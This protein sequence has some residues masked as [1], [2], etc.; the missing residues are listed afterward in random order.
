MAVRFVEARFELLRV[1]AAARG[2]CR[3]LMIAGRPA[4]YKATRCVGS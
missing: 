1:E 3:E 2:L 4:G